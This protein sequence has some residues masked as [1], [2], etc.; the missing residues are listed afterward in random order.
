MICVKANNQ[1]IFY[2]CYKQNEQFPFFPNP[3]GMAEGH[4]IAG[5]IQ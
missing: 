5:S 4:V 2:S 3:S 1:F